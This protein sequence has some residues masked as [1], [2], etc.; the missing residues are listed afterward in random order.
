[1][2]SPFSSLNQID[3]IF[4][5]FPAR[6]ASTNRMNLDLGG[7]EDDQVAGSS[8][9][10]TP[11]PC[12]VRRIAS[13]QVGNWTEIHRTKTS[14]HLHSSFA[15]TSTPR[16]PYKSLAPRFLREKSEKPCLSHG[17]GVSIVDML[18]NIA[19]PLCH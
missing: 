8:Y 9:P 11:F 3:V 4:W 5:Y 17:R 19:I 16:G 6:S 13:R 7:F 2:P 12:R 18:G 10:P 15:N 14:S 1:M